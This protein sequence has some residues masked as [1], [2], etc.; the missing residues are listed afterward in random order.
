M[1]QRYMCKN[2]N[3]L[4]GKQKVK[5]TE[6]GRKGEVSALSNPQP[7]GMPDTCFHARANYGAYQPP[8]AVFPQ[9][10]ISICYYAVSHR[11]VNSL[12]DLCS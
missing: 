2:D 5:E 8:T 7:P 1:A 10:S 6:K 9:S 3:E 11:N 4:E 12:G